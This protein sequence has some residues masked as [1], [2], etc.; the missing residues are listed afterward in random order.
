MMMLRTSFLQV[1]RGFAVLLLFSSASLH[2]QET[3][4]VAAV[5]NNDIISLHDLEQRMRLA[6]V[7]SNLPDTL[8]SRSRI[9][10]QVLRS[11]IDE[12]LKTQEAERLKINI[13]ASEIASSLANIERQNNMPAGGLESFLKGRGIDPETMR[14]Q[15]RSE[16]SWV[17]VVRHEL[18]PDLHIGEAEIDER[19]NTLKANLGKPEYLVA[20]IYLAIDDPS[21][22]AEVR[23]LAERLIDQLRQGAPFPA[24]ARQFSQ[25]GAAGGDLGWVSEGALDPELTRAL[26]KLE[27]GNVT[28]PIH[29]VDGYH[30]MLLRDKRTVGQGEA[31]EPIFDILTVQLPILPGSTITE[32][33][34]Q[35]KQVRSIFSADKSCDDE[36]K[37]IKQTVADFTRAQKIKR[38]EIPPAISA[39]IA[40]LR[41]GQ[42]SEPLDEEGM[43]RLF[44]VCGRTD[45]VG[46]LPSR[47]DIRTRL[48]N[49]QIEIMAQRYLRDLRRS[50]FVEVR[51]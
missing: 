8:E 6:L 3:Q 18:L 29:T 41:F 35:L 30:I 42:I 23:T 21:R 11:L 33:D 27:K 12:R 28:P 10:P 22:E 43:R 31:S 17:R 50:A 44:A 34:E 32:R 4:R 14:Q 49:E 51:V 13:A 15:I 45:P 20:E 38:S 7:S 26:A 9:G 39:L 24:L 36:E 2:A 16:L 5:V 37:Q 46:N 25:N 19:L 47:D 48:E 40:N 1:L